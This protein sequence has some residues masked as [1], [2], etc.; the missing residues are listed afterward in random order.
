VHCVCNYSALLF[1]SK[2][3]NTFFF[4]YFQL[5]MFMRFSGGI[6]FCWFRVK[7]GERGQPPF[8]GC[9]K[10]FIRVFKD[11]ARAGFSNFI[12]FQA[13]LL[14]FT[15]MF[16]R[17]GACGAVRPV[18]I[19]ARD[20]RGAVGACLPASGATCTRSGAHTKTPKIS[21]CPTDF[22]PPPAEKKSF[23]ERGLPR[24]AAILPEHYYH[25]IFFYIFVL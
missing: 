20:L 24:R 13:F 18:R 25:L 17:C 16:A 7:I 12:A 9:F 3:F 14:S 4:N 5:S 15:F 21:R 10:K 11:T 23:P 19:G 22:D 8:S 1:N 2:T 6:F